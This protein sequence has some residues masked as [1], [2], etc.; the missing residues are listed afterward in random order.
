[1][2]AKLH[3]ENILVGQVTWVYS[4]Q[5]PPECATVQCTAALRIVSG[6]V[7]C[8]PEHDFAQTAARTTF[9]A[10]AQ[11]RRHVTSWC[12]SLLVQQ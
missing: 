4:H 3:V 10:S 1:M 5:R 8:T 11:R 2:W 9:L 6:R 7:E 12:P